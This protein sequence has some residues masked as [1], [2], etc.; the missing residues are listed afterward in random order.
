MS[1]INR[2]STISTGEFMTKS[3]DRLQNTLLVLLI[4]GVIGVGVRLYER[5]SRADAIAD[6][7]P[8]R[9]DDWKNYLTGGHHIGPPSA[10]ITVVEFFDFQC[11]FCFRFVS[12]LDS[13]MSAHPGE[14]NLVLRHY[15]LS[16]H[17]GARAAAEASECAADQTDF[18]RT[19]RVFFASPDSVLKR[20]WWHLAYT[21]GARDSVRFQTCVTNREFSTKVGI[22]SSAGES[23]AMIGTPTI[24]VNNQRF[25]GAPTLARLDSAI[26]QQR[27]SAQ[28]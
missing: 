1:A 5:K 10:P 21:A 7:A 18:F 14:I 3:T 23:L 11:P 8:V 20:A 25:D 6:G 22:D 9:Q 12:T 13:A 17:A 24:L 4:V 2:E 15:P 19:Y 16:A 28:R 26:F 27:N